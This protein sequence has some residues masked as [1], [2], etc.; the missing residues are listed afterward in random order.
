MNEFS[1]SG[2]PARLIPTAAPSAKEK[3][4]VSAF[5]ATVSAVRPLAQRILSRL[6]VSIPDSGNLTCLTEITFKNAKEKSG[7]PD[8]LIYF[9][10]GKKEWK[11]IVEAKT[12]K[13]QIDIEQLE[14]YVDLA[15]TNQIDALIT[16]SNQFTAFPDHHPLGAEIDKRR[17]GSVGLFHLSWQSILTHVALLHSDENYARSAGEAYILKEFMRFLGHRASGVEHFT[18]MNNEWPDLVKRVQ[19]GASIHKNSSE[20]LNT[21][22]SWHQE[23]R[24]LAL[25]M[26]EKTKTSAALYISRKHK[27]DPVARIKEDAEVLASRNEL[28]LDL[29]IPNV[30]GNIYVQ[31]DI[32]GRTLRCSIKVG[33]PK[34]KKRTSARVN[35]LL[36]QLSQ[37]PGSKV[38]ICLRSKGRRSLQVPLQKVRDG[39]PSVN[40][41]ENVESFEII[42]VDYLARDFSSSRKFI[43]RLEKFTLSFYEHV[44][45]KLVPWIERPPRIKHSPEELEKE[46]EVMVSSAGQ[47]S[48]TP[49]P[50]SP[51]SE[52]EIARE[53]RP[54]TDGYSSSQE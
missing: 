1:V 31:A 52:A 50:K 18:K 29:H 10:R 9:K 22:A 40:G 39:D 14:Q 6:G 13:A 37:A 32:K 4:T 27:N 45:E 19:E 44:G 7:R 3:R 36:R 46:S 30:A 53:D 26:S 25:L 48:S 41:Y 16:I 51:A 42:M 28:N 17:L 49:E 35:W 5:L 54:T 20:A 43:E 21:V 12:D 33:A 24:D 8:G 11:A 34:D 2:E 23:Q 38:L 47:A 15:K